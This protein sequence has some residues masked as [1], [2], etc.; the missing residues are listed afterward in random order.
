MV[1]RGFVAQVQPY[2]SKVLWSRTVR[3]LHHESLHQLP[4]SSTK[5]TSFFSQFGFAGEGLKTRAVVEGQVFAPLADLLG[6]EVIGRELEALSFPRR[7]PEEAADIA[8]WMDALALQQEPAVLTAQVRS[9]A[10]TFPK[11]SCQA[12]LRDERAALAS[13]AECVRWLYMATSERARV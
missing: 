1:F 13:S 9:D 4:D 11:P 5:G 3:K 10:D 12:D 6:L 7:Y 2:D 8:R